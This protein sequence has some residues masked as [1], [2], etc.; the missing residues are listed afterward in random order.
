M[1]ISIV[2]PAYNEEETIK[3]CVESCIN[4]TRMADNIIVANDGSTD[5]TGEILDSFWDKINVIHIKENTWNKSNVQEI[6][7]KEVN[8]D[9]FIA[10][11]ADTILDKDFVKEI[12]ISFNSQK[13]IVA[14]CG[15]VI[16]MKDN[17]ITACRELEYIIGQDLHKSAQSYMNSILILPWCATAY[18]TK[19]F[20]KNIS[21]DHDTVA[22]DLDFSYKINNYKKSKY[23][24]F[25]KKAIV[26]TQD[27]NTISSYTYQL[28]RW[29][30]GGWQNLKKHYGNV[31]K[32]LFIFEVSI[33]YIEWFTF[34]LILFILPI[35]N[36][37]LFLKWLIFYFI[38]STLLWIYWAIKRKR[39]DLFF[40]SPLLIVFTIINSYIFLTEFY[41]QI[42][43]NQKT[44]TWFKPQR[45]KIN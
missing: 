19:F 38:Y 35:I 45:R 22:E 25:N 13:K 9:I 16:S 7:I 1:K 39:I 27:P 28:K 43:K 42:V 21:F 44:L 24:L 12:E 5:T 33:L 30:W 6:A 20:K 26:H 10:T 4:Q 36:L 8:D 40:Y 37:E 29:L 17:W 14:V 15:Y 34:A 11:D 41:K 23:I 3:A 2:I 32:F 18:N 31:N